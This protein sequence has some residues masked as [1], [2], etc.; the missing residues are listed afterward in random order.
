MTIYRVL[1]FVLAVLH[2]L[3]AGMIGLVGAFADGGSVPERLVVVI[4]HPLSAI[5]LL[6][7]V[8]LPGLSLTAVRVITALLGVNVTADMVIALLIAG[9]T[10]KGDWPLP[11]VFAVVPAIGIVYAARTRLRPQPSDG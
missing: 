2:L 8:V 10:L 6:L 3:F 1:I 5:G 4:V 7:M 11:L 9:G